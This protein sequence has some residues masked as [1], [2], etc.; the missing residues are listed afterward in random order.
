MSLAGWKIFKK[1][2]D[3]KPHQVRYW[4]NPKVE[5]EEELEEKTKEICEIYETLR[6]LTEQGIKV[7]ST[8][9]CTGIQ[10]KERLNAAKPIKFGTPRRVEYEIFDT[11][12]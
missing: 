6:E 9:E 10:A 1:E 7:Y 4:L 12:H 8:D 3:L 5:S 11:G 2:S